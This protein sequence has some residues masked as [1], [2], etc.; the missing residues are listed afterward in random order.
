MVNHQ[1]ETEANDLAKSWNQ[2][3]SISPMFN[4]EEMDLSGKTMLAC[5]IYL[6]K[7]N[8]NTLV[9]VS[10]EE[11]TELQNKL[12]TLLEM[13]SKITGEKNIEKIIFPK[14]FFE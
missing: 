13:T 2:F 1:Y 12:E 8:N 7:K 5:L 11:L 14:I 4:G 9:E 6:A 10:L 3:L